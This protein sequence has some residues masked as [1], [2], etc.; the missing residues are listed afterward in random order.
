MPIA[1]KPRKRERE[2]ERKRKSE[3]REEKDREERNNVK[4]YDER[5][6]RLKRQKNQPPGRGTG[7]R[8]ADIPKETKL[9]ARKNTKLQGIFDEY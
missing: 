8:G 5:G 4:S 7:R 9:Q 3:R 2:K 1:K 6:E